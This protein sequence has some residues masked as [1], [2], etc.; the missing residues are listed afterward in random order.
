MEFQL[1]AAAIAMLAVPRIAAW[2]HGLRE[3]AGS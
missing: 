1:V 3:D 2:A